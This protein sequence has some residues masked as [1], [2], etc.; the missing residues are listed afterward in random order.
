MSTLT[1]RTWGTVETVG[2]FFPFVSRSRGGHL[3]VPFATEEMVRQAWI[4]MRVII[5][6]TALVSIP[7]G[8]VVA[9]QIGSLPQQLGA[10]VGAARPPRRGRRAAPAARDR[11]RS[12]VR[13]VGAGP[14][15]EDGDHIPLRRTSRRSEVEEVLGATSLLLNDGG[16]E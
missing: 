13:R 3:A 11:R 8:A 15:L 4:I 12:A 7:L 16:L 5:A 9:L 14:R 6:P 1:A 2:D 10:H